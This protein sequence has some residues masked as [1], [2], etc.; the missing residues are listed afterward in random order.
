MQI[1]KAA[2]WVLAGVAL[3]AYLAGGLSRIS[4]NV[5]VLKMLPDRLGTVT[6]LSLFARH[7]SRPGELIVT[8]EAATPETADAAVKALAASFRTRPDVAERVVSES[9]WEAHPQELAEFLAYLLINQPPPAFQTLLDRMAP[10]Q[11]AKTLDDTKE[12]MADSM[13]ARDMAMAGY[14]PLGMTRSLDL[15]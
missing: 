4:F 3:L 13:D 5:D 10:G 2:K 7:F 12:T 11:I 15:E 14:D 6:G 1:S 9:P 8:V